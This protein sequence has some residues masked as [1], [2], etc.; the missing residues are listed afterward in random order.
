MV[1]VPA[2]ASLVLVL[3]F[4]L[5]F[6]LM[7]VLPAH[8]QLS[9]SPLPSPPPPPPVSPHTRCSTRPYYTELITDAPES[10]PGSTSSLSA[11][12]GESLRQ[13]LHQH[14]QSTLRRT[15]ALGMCR[16]IEC[17]LAVI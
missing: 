6:L 8:S 3:A 2:P 7:L 5:S 17:S 15:G 16:Y 10:T 13:E 11:V 9:F 4:L 1:L 12:S 14:Q